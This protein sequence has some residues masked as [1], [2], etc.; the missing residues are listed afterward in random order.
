MEKALEK[1]L[2][3]YNGGRTMKLIAAVDENW[4][5]G[6]GGQLLC[7]ISA[8]MKQFR[9]KTVGNVII[10]GRKTLLTFP[11]GKPLPGRENLVLTKDKTFALPGAT[12][13]YSVADAIE[14]VQAYNGKEIFI[15]GGESVYEQ[16][17]P[18]CGT[19]YITKIRKRFSQCDA[20]LANLDKNPQWELVQEGDEQRE[21][22]VAF[23]F[24]VYQRI[25]TP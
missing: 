24:A 11:G 21:G 8:D 23:T 13:C 4:G 9:E 25:G 14:K 3:R 20:F 2:W 22:D 16:F 1:S 6:Q 18:H 10:L 5:I 7:R 19:A 15:I 17:L 12:L